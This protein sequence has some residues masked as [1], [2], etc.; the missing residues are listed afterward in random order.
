MKTDSQK[1]AFR[2]RGMSCAA[3]SA[4]VERAASRI[5][6]VTS[7]Q[8]SLL[9][10]TM[11]VHYAPHQTNPEEIASTVCKL[12][13]ATTP[14]ESQEAKPYDDSTAPIRRRLIYSGA[15]LIPMM[16]LHHFGESAWGAWLQLALLCPILYFNRIFFKSG[17][18][19]LMQKS[20]NMDTLV[21]IG[22]I[23]SV[24]DGICEMVIHHRGELY[25]E[26]AAM[27]LTLITLGKWLEAGATRKTSSAVEKLSA[28]LPAT[29]TVL[30]DNEVQTIPADAVLEGDIV[31]I[32]P[33][34]SIPVDGTV[35][36]GQSTVNESS[37]TGES[38]PIEKTLGDMVYAA[39]TNGNGLLQIICNKTRE[40]SAMADII[41]LVGEAA[42]TKAPIA[43]I[44]DRVAGVFVPLVI[45]IAMLTTIIWL[46]AGSSAS[47]AISCGIAVLVIS[48]PCALGLATPVAIMAGVGKGAE[49]GILY[50]NGEALEHARNITCIAL[51]K[52]GT[53][54]RGSPA[55]CDIIPANEHSREEL[56]FLAATAESGSTHPLA[57]AIRQAC[58]TP[59]PRTP[60]ECLYHAGRGMVARVNGETILAGNSQLMQEHDIQYDASTLLHLA[61]E[62]KTPLLFAKNGELYGIIAVR[63]PIRLCAKATIETLQSMGIRICMMT[64]DNARTA[65]AVATQLGI[66]DFWA[67]CMP[68]D[69]EKRL[70][71]LREEGEIV[72]MVGDGINDAPALLRADV[73]ISLATGTD[74]AK[75]SAD[76]VLAH[77]NLHDAVNAIRLSRAVICN[78]RQNLFWAFAYNTLAIPLAAGVFYPLFGWLLHPAV[79]AAAMGMSSLCVV[80]N[81]LRLRH[82]SFSQPKQENMNTITL[83]VTG[84]MCPHCEQHVTKAL[85]ALDGVASCIASHKDNAVTITMNAQ[86]A[87]MA[88]IKA[89]ITEAGY[90]VQ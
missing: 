45:G 32:A 44:A 64:G 58:P 18:G 20:P 13:Y 57:E 55:V 21:S 47:F 85:L 9:A 29:A 90:Q 86:A 66:Q 68:G 72:G 6:G 65:A 84:M 10:G 79:S 83:T 62:G 88:A 8:V 54:T 16:F 22:A 30:R 37:L 40:N 34:E 76:I 39:T 52:T 71:Q 56:L 42:A 69:K 31:L 60:D 89:A 51:D 59:S 2:V 38:L 43:R 61:Q 63:D 26:S 17:L 11:L 73:G 25:F 67:E 24:A 46:L 74:I 12:G 48:C 53:I 1:Q 70:S 28:L 50:R 41:R 3:C 35:T 77:D 7:V 80:S 36:Q 19:A 87:D 82:L 14:L 4:R 49:C 81:A 75:E 78:I 27:I 15:L 5:P 33:G 23:A